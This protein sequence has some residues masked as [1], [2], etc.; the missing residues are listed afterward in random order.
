MEQTFIMIKPDGVK[1]GIIGQVISRFEAKGYQLVR[2]SVITI[3]PELAEKHYEAHKRRDFF[4]DLV[5]FITSGS[6]VPMVW[7]GENI[8]EESRNL[9][10][11]TDPKKADPGT[12]R[13]DFGAS[14]RSNVIHGSDSK[15]NALREIGLFFN[16]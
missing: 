1:K 15:E 7:Q 8:I 10:G 9:I 14:I 4:N 12:I 13:A 2:A 11:A 3:S 5:S 6:V 16:I